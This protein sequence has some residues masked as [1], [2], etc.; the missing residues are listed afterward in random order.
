MISSMEWRAIPER[1]NERVRPWM[2]AALIGLAML[3]SLVLGR[4]LDR[5]QAGRAVLL[6]GVIVASLPLCISLLVS[7]LQGNFSVDLLAGL[8]IGTSLVLREYWVA[9]IIILM[10]AGGGALEEHATRRASSVLNA[11]AKRMPQVAHLVLDDG[12]MSDV[13]IDAIAVGQQVRIFPHEICPVDGTVVGGEGSMDESYLTGEPFLI[14]KTRG[15]TVLSGAINGNA[16]LTIEATKVASDS[17]YAKIVE[18]LH[19]SEQ[20]RPRIRRLGDRI[21]SWYTPLA[22]I[23]AALAWLL[24]GHAERFLAVLVIATPC[25]LLIAIPV[26]VIGA[27]SVGAKRGILI[28]DSSILEKLESCRILVV[29]KT[30]TLTYGKP[31]LREIVTLGGLG[32]DTVLTLTASLER[33]SKHPLSEAIREAASA[34]GLSLVEVERVSEDPGEGLSGETGGHRITVTGR[35]KLSP[36]T[37]EKLPPISPGLECVVLAEGEL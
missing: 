1:V 7:A 16:A 5:P 32:R 27:I 21:G 23:I 22:L 17:R 36:E 30:G 33:Y 13:S 34:E 12:S 9:G 14:E 19:A 35:G 29:D 20:E 28:K 31:R 25:P 18:V 8:S 2:L 15:A 24:S 11:L 4:V 37:R 3:L 26:A 10:L 6:V